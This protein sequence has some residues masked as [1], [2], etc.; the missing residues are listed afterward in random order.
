[1]T[2]SGQW[3]TYLLLLDAT[4]RVVMVI[5]VIYQVGGQFLGFKKKKVQKFAPPV[6]PLYPPSE[7]EAPGPASS[8]LF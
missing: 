1:M 8:S 5:D 4:F 6:T 7:E 3:I 2:A